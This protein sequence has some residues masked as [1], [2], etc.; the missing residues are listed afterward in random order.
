MKTDYRCPACGGISLVA[1][2]CGT[3]GCRLE[4]KPL[5]KHEHKI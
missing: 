2:D 3:K 5:K 1:K 4:G